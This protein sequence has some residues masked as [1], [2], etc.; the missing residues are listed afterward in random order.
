MT[1]KTISIFNN[2]GGVGKT[3]YMYHV[4]HLL[5]EQ[6]KTVLMVDLDSQCNLSAYTLDDSTLLKSWGGKRGHGGNS[7]WRIIEP[8]YKGIGDFYKRKPTKI[9]DYLHLIPGDVSLSTFEDLL[10]DTWNAAKGGAEQALRVQTA[11]YRYIV[12]CANKIN[13]DI[14]MLD[15]GPNLGA[16]NRAALAGSDYFIIPMSP[17]LFSIRGTENLGNKLVQWNKDWNQIHQAW[18]G[19][20]TLE[21][22]KGKPSFLGYVT[23]QHNSR[24]NKDGMTKGWSIFGDRVD[25]S[26]QENIVHKLGPINQVYNW[27]QHQ[28][29][30]KLG[31]IPNLHSLI[32][33]SLE[34]KKPVFNCTYKEGLTG[35]HITRAKETRMHFDS[36]MSK[37]SEII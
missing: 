4:A 8:V 21:L 19:D 33:Y 9:N 13:A 30:S 12:F 14:V 6:N 35:A 2:K 18:E 10:G 29:P 27:K 3:T 16:L 26:V 37:L 7:I 28:T 32:P 17:D 1:F 36:I 20:D 22:P 25:I 5:A 31:A 34:A 23:Q 15:L 24:T 11:I